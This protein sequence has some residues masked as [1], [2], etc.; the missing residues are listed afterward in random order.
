L[1]GRPGRGGLPPGED[2]IMTQAPPASSDPAV[3]A[4]PRSGDH[5]DWRERFYLYHFLELSLTDRV[6]ERRE[7][8]W[9]KRYLSDRHLT[10]LLPRMQEIVAVG[11]CDR[12]ELRRLAER[13]SA[14]LSKG[15]KRRFLTNLAQLF[16]S[17]GKLAPEEYERILDLAEKIGVPDV[18]ADAIVH[19][20]YSINDTF[21]AILGLLALGAILYF[22]QV[23]IVPLVIAIFITMIINKVEGLIASAFSLHRFRWLNKA[24]AMVV[25]LGVI[26]GLIMAAVVSGSEVAD[27]VPFYETKIGTA[28]DN[29][30]LAQSGLAWARDNGVL[31]QLQDLPVGDM[32]GSF[33]GSAVSFLSNF[34][35]I[36]I[37]TGFLV[38]SSTSF[39]GILEEMNAKIGTYISV[40]TLINLVTGLVVLLLCLVFG[41]DFAIFW[42]V[43]TFLLNFIPSIGSIIAILPP[44][45]LSLI[46]LDSWTVNVVFIVLFVGTQVV[47]AQVIEPKVMGNRLNIKPLAILLGLIF[48]GFLW[49]IPGMF[50]A[51]PLMVLLR[52]LSGYFNFS[53][54]FERLLAADHP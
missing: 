45:L 2:V 47:L 52:I 8:V 42:A 15:E 25:I 44:V 19:S 21:L 26:F 54:G 38:F 12:E 48:W 13:A 41:I 50:L 22:A 14:E 53:R 6:V 37:F 7:L 35:L 16:K 51:T 1:L 43:L 10:S 17:K 9:I 49:G 4:P 24:F 36:A 32:V 11:H 29:S 18:E 27:R 33:L 31:R 40:K 20:V 46:Q 34:V 39:T 5:A 30:E 3:P 28:I 23:V